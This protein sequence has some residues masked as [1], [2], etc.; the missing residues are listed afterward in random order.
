MNV[1]NVL[2]DCGRG[3]SPLVSG[4][5]ARSYGAIFTGDRQKSPVPAVTDKK[6]RTV[7]L[8]GSSTAFAHRS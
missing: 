2:R 8:C 6:N 5:A 1:A 3:P 7:V 4:L